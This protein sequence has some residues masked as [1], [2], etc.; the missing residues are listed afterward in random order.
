MNNIN[1]SNKRFVSFLFGFILHTHTHSKTNPYVFTPIAY[2]TNGFL[3]K[4]KLCVPFF[5][6]SL[7]FPLAVHFLPLCPAKSL[8]YYRLE[9]ALLNVFFL[10]RFFP[11]IRQLIAHSLWRFPIRNGQ[12]EPIPF[13][14][15]QNYLYTLCNHVTYNVFFSVVFGF[16]FSIVFVVCVR[17]CNWIAY[18]CVVNQ[19]VKGDPIFDIGINYSNDM[20]P[21]QNCALC[22]IEI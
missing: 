14:F 1:D 3:C 4:W 19:F 2:H 21:M 15:K 17:V 12:T 11:S 18:V 6:F 22:I 8:V 7:T 9:K 13:S 10:V 5:C 16:M 20:I